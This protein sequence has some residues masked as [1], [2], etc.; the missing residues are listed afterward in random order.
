M[1]EK[2][3]LAAN[4]P[5]SLDLTVNENGQPAHDLG[6][7]LG[8]PAHCVFINTSSLAYVH[9]H[10]M[11]RNGNTNAKGP[12]NMNMTGVGPLMELH[13]PALPAGTYKLWLQFRGGSYSSTP[14]RLR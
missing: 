11:V 14:C 8:A 1:L 10:P 3:T 9:I 6:S 2:T 4:T 12:M 5:Q 7:Y 13:V